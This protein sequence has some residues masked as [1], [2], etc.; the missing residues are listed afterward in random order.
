MSKQ[1]KCYLSVSDTSGMVIRTTGSTDISLMKFMKRLPVQ[2]ISYFNTY[3]ELK[4]SCVSVCQINPSMLI[5][6]YNL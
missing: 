6:S 3:R 1:F 2:L 5:I 4:P